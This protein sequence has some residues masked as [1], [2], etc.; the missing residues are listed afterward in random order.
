MARPANTDVHQA[1]A[2][3]ARS[4]AARIESTRLQKP[5]TDA[6]GCRT[7]STVRAGSN[8]ATRTRAAGAG[9]GARG[10]VWCCH[11]SRAPA[12]RGFWGGPSRQTDLGRQ[13]GAHWS[14]PVRVAEAE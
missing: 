6:A 5:C 3:Y 2:P 8:L 10:G 12:R 11:Q 7:L 1:D 14:V 13:P 4:L 9:S